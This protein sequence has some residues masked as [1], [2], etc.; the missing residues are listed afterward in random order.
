M[1]SFITAAAIVAAFA[2]YPALAEEPAGQEATRIEIDQKAKAFI[3]VV[4]DEP[5]ALLDA[6]GLHVRNAIVYG[7][8]LTDAGTLSF[9]KRMEELGKEAADD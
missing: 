9:D 6:H 8:T 4:D 7:D 3:F 5:V 1:R 2:G